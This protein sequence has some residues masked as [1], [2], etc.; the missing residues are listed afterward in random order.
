MGRATQVYVSYKRRAVR[1]RKP[2]GR[3]RRRK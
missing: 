2:S 3:R 1:T